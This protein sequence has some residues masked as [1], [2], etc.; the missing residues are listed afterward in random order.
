MHQA[1]RFAA[2]RAFQMAMIYEPLR[3]VGLMNATRHVF[4][5][6]GTVFCHHS[7]FEQGSRTMRYKYKWMVKAVMTQ[8]CNPSALSDAN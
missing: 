7:V 8:A 3:M 4:G 2:R 1:C 5:M 6:E